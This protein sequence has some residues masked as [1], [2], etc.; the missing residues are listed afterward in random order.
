MV[1]I[2]DL[3]Q[4][5]IWPFVPLYSGCVITR[6]LKKWRKKRFV[7]NF[8]ATW[9]RKMDDQR[10]D[11]IFRD[12]WRKKS[13]LRWKTTIQHFPWILFAL[14]HGKSMNNNADSCYRATLHDYM[15]LL[16]LNAN[17]AFESRLFS[18]RHPETARPDP[19]GRSCTAR[20]RKG[21]ASPW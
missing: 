20:S 1:I 4:T 11:W 6:Q 19:R 5:W 14:Y 16:L 2:Y 21:R 7:A 15:I 13:L 10:L 3:P 18:F 8:K 17:S 12:S 9:N